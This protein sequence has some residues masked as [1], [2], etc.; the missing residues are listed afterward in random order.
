[1]CILSLL[2]QCPDLAS[3][4][5]DRHEKPGRLPRRKA[6]YCMGAYEDDKI[7]LSISPR[8]TSGHCLQNQY[9]LPCCISAFPAMR[10]QQPSPPNFHHGLS[11]THA[12]QHDFIP[13]PT[14]RHHHPIISTTKH[15][16]EVR[17]EALEKN[18][19]KRGSRNRRLSMP[20]AYSKTLPRSPATRHGCLGALIATI[21]G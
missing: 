4:M 11:T 17:P 12:Q 7:H 16:K 5:Q 13:R 15:A 8:T 6:S 21:N 14:T 19:I 18:K 10:T 3:A 20:I 9:T 2:Q 1:M